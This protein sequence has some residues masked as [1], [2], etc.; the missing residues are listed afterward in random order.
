MKKIY[1]LILLLGLFSL[2]AWSDA[3][4]FTGTWMGNIAGTSFQLQLWT[5]NGEWNALMKTDNVHETLIPLGY[6]QEEGILYLFR[7]AVKTCLTI[8]SDKKLTFMGILKKDISTSVMLM[9]I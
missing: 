4:N 7:P 1:G 5:V 3:Q 6:D 8:Y 9:R 2:P